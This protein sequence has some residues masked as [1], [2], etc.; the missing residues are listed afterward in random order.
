MEQKINT[1]DDEKPVY[2]GK[3]AGII[4]GGA[5]VCMIFGSILLLFDED[6]EAAIGL[7]IFGSVFC[8]AGYLAYRIFRPPEG[9]KQV[10]FTERVQS[11]TSRYGQTGERTSKQY[12]YVDEEMPESE[13]KDMQE[14]YAS[15][16]WTQRKDWAAGKVIQ[17][18]AQNLG[19]L[20]IFTILWNLVS[21]GITAF[22][23]ISE[24]ES[25]D[26]PWFM[27]IFPLVGLILIIVTIRT[28]IRRRK[29]GISIMTLDTVP[30]YLGDKLRASIATGVPALDNPARSFNVKFL[31]AEKKSSRDR[32]G[33][34]RVTVR[35]IWSEDH[36]VYGQLS[37]SMKTFT[38]SIHFNVPSDLP[39]THLI[40]EDDRT[41]WKVN[42]TSKVPGVDY[43]AQFEVPVY[44]QHTE[45][46]S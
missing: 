40:P 20:I 1:K 41:L 29:F 2:I 10:L 12:V 9:K 3:L 30:A 44:P 5:G 23:F 42:V 7:F 14:E 4:F 32:E 27:L 13:I 6:I 15:K 39:P 38:I 28:W 16:P 34:K 25:G 33:K 35:E 19:F 8:S 36:E 18:G 31:C 37:E 11:M 21:N 45:D 46:N 22:A 24:W 43:A 17:E 26:V